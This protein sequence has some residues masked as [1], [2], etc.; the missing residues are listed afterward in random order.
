VEAGAGRRSA[1][2][3]Q[4]SPSHSLSPLETENRYNPVSLKQ[5]LDNRAGESP[6]RHTERG[7]L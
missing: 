6:G 2:F 1:R 4:P 7:D 3:L 5:W